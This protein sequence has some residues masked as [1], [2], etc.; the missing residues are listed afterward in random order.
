MLFSTKSNRSAYE[1]GFSAED[2]VLMRE[3]S[4][5]GPSSVADA[6][7]A[8]L[9]LPMRPQVRSMDIDMSAA[10]ALGEALRQASPCPRRAC[11]SETAA[12]NRDA[13]A[14]VR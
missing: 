8:Q 11:T 2:V 14:A 6:C 3:E 4:E 10:L 7:N 1:F 5:D 9:R 13:A 12:L